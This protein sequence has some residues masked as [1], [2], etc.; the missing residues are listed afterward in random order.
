MKRETLIFEGCEKVHVAEENLPNPRRGQVLVRAL[1][2][3]ISARSET[4]IYRGQA[5]QVL[6]VDDTVPALPGNPRYPLKA[7]YSSVGSVI[8]LGADVPEGW[9]GQRV[10]SFHPHESHYL[11]ALSEL[12]PVPNEVALEDAVFLPY[13][14]TAINLLL[15]G[16]PLVGER[17][18]VFGQGVFGLLTTALLAP[19][20]L[21]ALVTFDRFPVRRRE[22]LKLGATVCLDPADGRWL[23]QVQG[24]LGKDGAAAGADLAFELSGNPQAL[25]TAVNLAGAQGRV[26]IG[27]WYGQGPINL[28]LSERFH[29]NR[30]RLIC[31][32]ASTFPDALCGRWSKERRLALAWLRLPLARP[33]GW[34]THRFS[35]EEA[36]QA[37]QMLAEAPQQTIQV[38]FTYD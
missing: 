14:E 20:P 25:N 16:Q 6:A 37:Y 13:M 19:F 35:L 38:V 26:V 33:S 15:D 9:L 17:V 28:E 2:S 36:A 29:R 10:F 18:L 30:I 3:A 12:L 31:S 23:E 34:I 8:A 11:A 27:P 5:D 1:I 32:R 24:L 21:A 7:G 4:L 22:S